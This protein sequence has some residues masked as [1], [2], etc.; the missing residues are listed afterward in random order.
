MKKKI[1]VTILLLL[2]VGVSFFVL[3]SNKIVYKS[4]DNIS[5]ISPYSKTTI[6]TSKLYFIDK[7]QLVSEIRAIKIEKQEEKSIIMELKKGPKIIGNLSPI[8][9]N[10]NIISIETSDR[11]C[12]VN[13]SN[14]FFNEEDEDILY[15]KIMAITN[16]ITQLKSI[17]Y[18]QLLNDGKKVKRKVSDLD[19]ESIIASDLTS[20]EAKELQQKDIVAKFLDNVEKGRYDLAYDLIDSRSRVQTN[21][22]D[23]TDDMIKMKL[24][25]AGYSSP[26]LFTKIENGNYMILVKYSLNNAYA[27]IDIMNVEGVPNERELVSSW[28]LLEEYGVW[29]INYGNNIEKF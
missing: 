5:V 2:F 29:K 16:S 19:L 14:N 6:K 21:Y 23:F 10:V 26:R 18:I 1:M 28:S 4:I 13:L 27:Q 15:L 11:V 17:D 25:L 20:V 9:K 24:K 8:P 12:F 22:D 7:N 3:S